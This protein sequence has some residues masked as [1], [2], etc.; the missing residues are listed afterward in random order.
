[1]NKGFDLF[2]EIYRKGVHTVTLPGFC[3]TIIEDMAQMTATIT[4]DD[5]S[6]DHSMTFVKNVTDGT[7]QGIIE[8]R[9][10]AS[11]F[12]FLI[13]VEQRCKT[14]TTGIG[15]FLKVQIINS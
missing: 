11:T 12:K 1:M 2:F 5:L 4:T 8:G 7:F 9:P 10:S 13:T 3:W 14:G 6:P 15:A